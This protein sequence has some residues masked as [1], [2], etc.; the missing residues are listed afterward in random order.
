[1]GTEHVAIQALVGEIS[2][3]ATGLR[4][5]AAARALTALLQPH[6]AAENDIVL[7]SLATDPDISL[8]DLLR[9]MHHDFAIR[10]ASVDPDSFGDERPAA[11]AAD[12]VA[13]HGGCGCGGTDEELPELD[14]RAI[15]HAIR[16]ATVFGAFDAIPA[17]GSFVLVAR[18]DPLPLLH[19][20]AQRAAGRLEVTYL[21]RGPQAWRLKL[22]R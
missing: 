5:A 22:T 3:A 14:V 1:M 11:H 8:T 15:P 4:A 20:L 21:E 10:Q 7:P 12:R 2:A 18:H 17:G 6:L 13:P 16:H 9:D 19:Q